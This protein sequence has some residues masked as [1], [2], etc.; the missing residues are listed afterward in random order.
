MRL[1]HGLVGVVLSAPAVVAAASP[2]TF[3][4]LVDML[5]TIMN[6]AVTLLI[7][8]AIVAYFIG[9]VQHIVNHADSEDSWETR[10][11]LMMGLVVLFVMV[12]IWGILA[13][14]QNTVG[15]GSEGMKGTTQEGTMQI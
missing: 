10:K 15:L 5:V 13:L 7:T 4:D 12:S 1:K 3:K 11:F 8:G 6:A 2:S 14:L 9:A